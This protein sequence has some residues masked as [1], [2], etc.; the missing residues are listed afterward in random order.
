[1]LCPV[2]RSL[3]PLFTW[4]QTLML[5]KVVPFFLSQVQVSSSIFIEFYLLRNPFWMYVLLFGCMLVLWLVDNYSQ[6]CFDWLINVIVLF[7]FLHGD[8][9][10]FDTL[11][12]WQQFNYLLLIL[13]IQCYCPSISNP[14]AAHINLCTFHLSQLSQ[15]HTN[16]KSL[17]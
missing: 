8:L 17:M 4:L 15:V 10:M 11:K 12:Y 16:V 1:M 14:T 7:V 5:V 13:S 3:N 2:F 6:V 9:S